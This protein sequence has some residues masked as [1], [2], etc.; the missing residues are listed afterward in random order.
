VWLLYFFDGPYSRYEDLLRNDDA[1]D[2][3]FRR[4]MLA[5][6]F[7]FQPMAL[8]RLYLSASHDRAIIDRA[9]DVIEKILRSLAASQLRPTRGR[10]EV[11][12]TTA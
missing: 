6:R 5:H 1:L 7:I 10:K 12:Q 8:K 2:A 4:Q 11:K 9:L 3:E